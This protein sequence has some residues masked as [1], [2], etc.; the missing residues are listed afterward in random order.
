MGC[1]Q[2]HS[3][4]P[5]AGGSIDDEGGLGP[6]RGGDGVW[7]SEAVD[8]SLDATGGS[9]IA[10]DDDGVAHVQYYGPLGVVVA[11]RQRG[12]WH[13]EPIEG[14]AGWYDLSPL[15]VDAQGS[16]HLSA[17]LGSSVVYATNASGGW[18]TEVVAEGLVSAAQATLSL[19]AAG[20]PTVAYQT[21]EGLW[22]ASRE[23][24]G[25]RAR[26]VDASAWTNFLSLALLADHVVIGAVTGRWELVVWVEGD[27]GWTSVK[28]DDGPVYG[29]PKMD[30]MADGALRL[31]YHMDAPREF[32][33]AVAREDGSIEVTRIPAPGGLED[34]MDFAFEDDGTL[35]V[36]G[37]TIDAILHAEYRGTWATEVAAP[38]TAEGM[39]GVL[40]ALGRS[41][42]SVHFLY[43]EFASSDGFSYVPVPRVVESR[44][45]CRVRESNRRS[46][47]RESTPT[48]PGVG[49]RPSC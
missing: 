25:W 17:A 36:G 5:D 19:D 14:S 9:S 28:V 4:G 6:C 23:A 20:G 38:R 46:S 8:P 21:A 35:H 29:R 42:R 15:A 40:V 47:T 26:L 34:A 13:A 16:S 12:E 22:V 45:P 32:R 24:S 41:P 3:A 11:S 7:R 48:S 39:D 30:G 37:L 1:A 10:V 18:T 31:A 27:A 49:A 44:E 33:R 43:Q 2:T